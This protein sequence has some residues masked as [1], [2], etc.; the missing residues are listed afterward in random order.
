MVFEA[1]GY[2]LFF[3]RNIIFI[4]DRNVGLEEV[5]PRIFPMVSHLYCLYHLKLNLMSPLSGKPTGLQEH[6]D[7]LFSKCAYAPTVESFHHL[8]DQLMKE[9]GHNVIDFLEDLLYTHWANTYFKGQRYR[10]MWSNPAESFNSWVEHERHLPFTQL[11][12]RIRI[13]LIDQIAERRVVEKLL[14][15]HVLEDSFQEGRT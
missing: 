2:Y 8:L 7:F 4:S 1:C 14:F 10:E 9:G 3:G 15:V 6:L 12:Y 13:R 5:L 11:I